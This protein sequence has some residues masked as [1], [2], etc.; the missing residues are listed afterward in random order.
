LQRNII[1]H[2]TWNLLSDD[3]VIVL[4]FDCH[5]R[6][7]SDILLTL[8]AVSVFLF[9]CVALK[10]IRSCKENRM[11]KARTSGIDPVDLLN[12]LTLSTLLHKHQR[13]TF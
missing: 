3:I 12:H 2:L 1:M 8:L 10:L 7:L 13:R 6:F 11:L 9:I 4:C 5:G